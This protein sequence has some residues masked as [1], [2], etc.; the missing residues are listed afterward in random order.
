[1]IGDQGDPV[2]TRPARRPKPQTIAPNG[3]FQEQARGLVTLKPLLLRPDEAAVFVGSI[4]L[5]EAFRSDGWVRPLYEQHRLVLFSV[6]QLEACVARLEVGDRPGAYAGSAREVAP[7]MSTSAVISS[8]FVCKA[9][10]TR[11][12]MREAA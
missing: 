7:A 9:R 11:R 6:R 4:A 5:L 8:G 1:M 2:Q 12:P 10:R 3:S